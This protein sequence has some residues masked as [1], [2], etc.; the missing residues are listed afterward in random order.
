[1][2][3]EAFA[4]KSNISLRHVYKLEEGGSSPA[5]ETLADWLGTCGTS[6][7]ALF[8][9]LLDEEEIGQREANKQIIGLCRR[10]LLVPAKRRVIVG[11]LQGLFPHD[12]EPND[13][14][15]SPQE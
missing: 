11:V 1:M 6:L 8:A 13:R 10:A 9:E 15:H 4:R 3:A 12:A 14:T 2:T 5:V 7:G